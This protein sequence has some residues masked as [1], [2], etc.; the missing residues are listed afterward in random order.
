MKRT[1]LPIAS[2][3]VTGDIELSRDDIRGCVLGS[4]GRA[5]DRHESKFAA[6]GDTADIWTVLRHGTLGSRQVKVQT[7]QHVGALR[8]LGFTEMLLPNRKR[9]RLSS[10]GG[11]TGIRRVRD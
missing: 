4:R 3:F 7:P 11:L 5:G 9:Y 10:W 8:E 2:G 1:T 6:E